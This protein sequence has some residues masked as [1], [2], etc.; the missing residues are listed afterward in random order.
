MSKVYWP[1]QLHG[2]NGETAVFDKQEDVPVGWVTWDMRHLLA[3]PDAP[4]PEDG[5]EAFGGHSKA[6]MIQM[7]RQ[8]GEKVHANSTPRTLHAKLVALG[9]ISAEG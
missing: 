6:D 4:K 2:P 9:K 1:K 8:A 7:L 3:A 5:P